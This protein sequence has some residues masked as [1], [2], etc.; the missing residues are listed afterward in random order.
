MQDAQE[1]REAGARERLRQL[2]HCLTL[3][4]W[5]LA[6]GADG[7][8]VV[9]AEVL[10]GRDGRVALD[11][12]GGRGTE[13]VLVPELQREPLVPAVVQA[14]R[15]VELERRLRRVRPGEAEELSLRFSCRPPGPEGVFGVIEYSSGT[16]SETPDGFGG[17][18]RPLPP[19]RAGR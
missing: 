17:L 11:A 9:R 19:P 12:R 8:A 14:G 16:T 13:D 10:P 4:G 18:L 3:V 7:G 6:P 1:A 5:T 15:P 2:G